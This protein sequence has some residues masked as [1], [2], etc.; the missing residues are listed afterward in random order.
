MQKLHAQQ[1][2]CS[3]GT[4]FKS[5]SILHRKK[6]LSSSRD[7][8]PAHQHI[9]GYLP[10][11]EGTVKQSANT[12]HEQLMLH[13]HPCKVDR[14]VSRPNGNLSSHGRQKVLLK[15]VTDVLCTTY[16]SI[17]STGMCCLQCTEV[18]SVFTHRPSS[19]LH[20][21]DPGKEESNIEG[22]VDEGVC[23]HLHHPEYHNLLAPVS[24]NEHAES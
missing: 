23:N 5:I 4:K 9:P 14:L 3:F 19:P 11:E 24:C 12:A 17:F 8:C 18:S 13:R 21:C 2:S 10:A 15:L 6:S 22:C 16:S 20:N 7:A 1:D